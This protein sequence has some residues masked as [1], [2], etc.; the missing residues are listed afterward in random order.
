M[1]NA[2]TVPL[3]ANVEAGHSG[4]VRPPG[5]SGSHES[6]TYTVRWSPTPSCGSVIAHQLPDEPIL[7]LE[8]LLVYSRECLSQGH[9]IG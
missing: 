8:E 9:G 3:R 4:H 1:L 6:V 2:S 5:P 7:Y